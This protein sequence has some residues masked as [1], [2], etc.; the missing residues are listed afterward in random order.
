MKKRKFFDI[1]AKQKKEIEKL[2]S[3]IPFASQIWFKNKTKSTILTSKYSKFK[4]Q[5]KLK[6]IENK[7]FSLRKIPLSF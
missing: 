2:E 7:I 6:K 5:L 3:I 4:S 1:K